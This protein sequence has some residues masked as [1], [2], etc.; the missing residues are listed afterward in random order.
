MK[1]QV[2]I[3]YWQRTDKVNSQG[4]APISCRI[5]VRGQHAEVAANIRVARA[6]WGG[7]RVR[8][9]G[10]SAE[11]RRHNSHLLQMQNELENLAADLDRQGKVVTAQG[12]ARL[13]RKG[14]TPSLSV[15]A[16][17][18]AYQ[19]ERQTLV[20]VEL[21][22]TT[23]K[24]ETTAYHRLGD[25]LKSQKQ[26]DLRPEELT[27]SIADRFVQWLLVTLGH[28]RNSANK[29][30]HTLRRV[31]KWGVRR[32]YL[33]KS[34]LALYECKR[35]AAAEIKFL[36]EAELATLASLEL[37]ET[38]N[39]LALVRDCFVLQCWTGLAYADLAALNVA[40]A[41]DKRASGGRRVLHLTRA[42][43]AG[44][45]GYKC[46]IPLMPEA[47]RI[48]GLYNDCLPVPCNQNYNLHLKELGVLAGIDKDKMHSHIGRKTAGTLMLNRGIPLEAVSSFLGHSST[49]ITQKI[50]AKLLDT[51]VVDAFEAAFG[52]ATTAPEPAYMTAQKGGLAA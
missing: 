17:F 37:P 32:E 15:L 41:L 14:N 1:T 13:L 24:Q 25:F 28:K 45:N 26:T 8:V 21:A 19:A 27:P 48:L 33:E 7:S 52:A 50:Y 39:N 43:S 47:E 30:L 9:L 38:G 23:I 46:V 42:K 3:I 40:A 5:T 18:E 11:V 10:R 20:G 2:G 35:A 12:L 51:T 4:Q 49:L 36:T 6:E 44:R 34:P 22:S 16:L 31:L 29:V